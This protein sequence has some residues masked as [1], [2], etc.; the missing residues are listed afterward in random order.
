MEDFTNAGFLSEEEMNL[1]YGDQEEQQEETSQ[2]EEN[3]D[4]SETSKQKKQVAEDNHDNAEDED[5]HDD[6]EDRNDDDSEDEGEDDYS[7][8]VGDDNQEDEEDAREKSSGSPKSSSIAKAFK[9]LGILSTLDDDRMK[10]IK[11]MD[12]LADAFEE[13]VQNRMEEHN[14]FVYDALQYKVPVSLIQQFESAISNLNSVSE[15]DLEDEKSEETRK[16]LI[17]QDLLIKG[18]TKEE[19]MELVEDYVE[20][21]KDVDKSKKAL[22][23]LKNVYTARYNQEIEKYKAVEMQRREDAKKYHKKLEDS[24]MKDDKIF[25]DLDI[26]KATRNKILD[27]I[28]KPTEKDENGNAMTKMYAE[29]KKDPITFNKY[30]GMFYVLTDGF[31]NIGKLIKGPVKKGVRKGLDDLE[32]VF[33]ST[34]RDMDGSLNFKS[35]VTADQNGFIDVADFDLIPPEN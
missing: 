18:H 2:E 4:K 24:I 8:S 28:R 6:D 34:S 1:L 17:Y 20:S 21:G 32:K 22:A 35:G 25:K 30:V 13:E 27:F 3:I 7:E 16:G 10:E 14:K 19:A 11:S 9:D 29:M 26:N 15:E 12:D 31:T 5:D 33:N 23:S